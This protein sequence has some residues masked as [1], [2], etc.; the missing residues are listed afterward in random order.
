MYSITTKVG[1]QRRKATVYA[2]DKSWVVIK[3][4]NRT[5]VCVAYHDSPNR[6][7]TEARRWT[8]PL[9]GVQAV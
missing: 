8:K 7:G 5:V 1:G 4:R 3:V 9:F 2:T 6:A